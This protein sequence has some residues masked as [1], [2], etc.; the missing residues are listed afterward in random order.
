MLA[1]AFV[2]LFAS[3]H[4]FVRSTILGRIL[5]GQSHPFTPWPFSPVAAASVLPAAV[6]RA[7]VPAAIP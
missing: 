6:P 5:N 4:Y 2:V 1:G 7:D 3:Y